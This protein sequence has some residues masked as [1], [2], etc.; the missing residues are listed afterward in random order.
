M[1][2]GNQRIMCFM[3]SHAYSMTLDKQGSPV[4]PRSMAVRCV[5][6]LLISFFVE[7]EYN[8]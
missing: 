2:V 4:R 1:I 3:P 5:H 6:G 8:C 7:Y